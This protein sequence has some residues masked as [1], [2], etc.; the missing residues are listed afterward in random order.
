MHLLG[1]QEMAQR[2]EMFP[3]PM[4]IADEEPESLKGSLV[5]RRAYDSF[6]SDDNCRTRSPALTLGNLCFTWSDGFPLF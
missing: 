1:V 5:R 2:V 6:L 3:F 4:A